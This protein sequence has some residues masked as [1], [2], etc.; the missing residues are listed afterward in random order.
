MPIHTYEILN[1]FNSELQSKNTEFE[2]KNKLKQLLSE[3]CYCLQSFTTAEIS[4]DIIMT[5][6]KPIANEQV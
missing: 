2:I 6:L 1:S 5:V 4:K 3:L